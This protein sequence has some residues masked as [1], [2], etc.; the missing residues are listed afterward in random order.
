[1]ALIIPV[2]FAQVIL[3][4]KHSALARTAVIT[5]GI[6]VTDAAGDFAVAADDQVLK[7]DN[8]W[9]SELDSNV[10]VGPATLRVGQ[11]G[12][13]PLA[14]EGSVTAAGD[15]SAA[16]LPP[17]CNLLVKKSTSLGGRRGRGRCF[18]PWVVQDAAC[19]EVGN[20]DGTSLGV[21]IADAET[22]LA[23][24]AGVAPGTY[25][26]PM[27]L[28]HDSRGAGTEPAPTLVTGVTCPALIAVQN[29]RIGRG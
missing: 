12:G 7:F 15:E 29:R 13:D 19:D 28:L 18:I 21:R 5:Y 26:S 22:W 20:I 24:L 2:G 17:N 27:Y 1:M 23:N 10:T 14:V 16:M 6:D 4:M 11:D 25:E 9:T 8:A 3:P